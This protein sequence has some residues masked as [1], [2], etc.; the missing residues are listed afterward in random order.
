MRKPLVITLLV[1]GPLSIV[2]NLP[3]AIFVGLTFYILP[4]LV[5]IVSPSLFILSAT[6]L[7]GGAVFASRGERV[8]RCVSIG[9]LLAASGAASSPLNQAC[10]Y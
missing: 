5:L 4:G 6:A 10:R 9:L 7:I 8:A 2:A 3:G 1:T